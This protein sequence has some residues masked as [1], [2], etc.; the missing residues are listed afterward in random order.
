M[1][2]IRIGVKQN[3]F[4]FIIFLFF[5]CTNYLQFLYN[6]EFCWIPK[7]LGKFL[8]HKKV[9]IN[10]S[11]V[12]NIPSSSIS[13][14]DD[15]ATARTS[16][17]NIIEKSAGAAIASYNPSAAI[18]NSNLC[19]QL[20]QQRQARET[21]KGT[22][23]LYA[24]MQTTRT[25]KTTQTFFRV[26]QQ[27]QQNLFYNQKQGQLQEQ[28]Q[29]KRQQSFCGMSAMAKTKKKKGSFINFKSCSF[30]KYI[31]RWYE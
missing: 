29:Q 16:D 8:K 23:G 17:Y 27:Q 14:V 18:N 12:I 2:L 7:T 13:V 22:A 20:Q 24:A 28:D 4:K 31:Y 1:K 30:H 10:Y 26:P 11:K 25:I 9:K 21:Q 15:S 5:Y 6:F 19:L 3:C